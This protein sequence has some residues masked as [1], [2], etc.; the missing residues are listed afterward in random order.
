MNDT[1]PKRMR[2]AAILM[3]ASTMSLG[4]AMA[5]V[6]LGGERYTA[7]PSLYLAQSGPDGGRPPR[8]AMDACTGKSA[9]AACSFD[10]PEGSVTGT[11]H[12]PDD[13]APAACVPKDTGSKG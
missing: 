7:E 5:T 11:C 1:F 8:E 3:V 13:N 4:G 10:A 6:L 12:A 2:V 9:G